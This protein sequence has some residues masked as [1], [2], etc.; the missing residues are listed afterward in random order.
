MIDG[1]NGEF[2]SSTIPQKKRS[3]GL[4]NSDDRSINSRLF[5]MPL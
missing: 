5:T 2:A 1:M 3:V 4:G